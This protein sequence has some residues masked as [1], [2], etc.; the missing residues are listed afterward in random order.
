MGAKGSEFPNKV[1]GVSWKPANQSLSNWI[2]P[3]AFALQTSGLLGN[4]KFN[5]V[6]GPRVRD[7]DLSLGKT[8]SL[9]EGFKLQFRAEA[10]NFTNTVS[11][12]LGSSGGGP[13]PPGG[14]GP[15]GPGGGG[16]TAITAYTGNTAGSVATTAGGFG[17]INSTAGS[18]A[19]RTFQFGLKL[20]Y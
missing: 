20:I 2:N 15:G 12:S 6:Q 14:G 19:P 11:L 5:D 10:F 8:F 9:L 4:A 18:Y 7:A 16:T 13:P 3:N 17:T 1:P